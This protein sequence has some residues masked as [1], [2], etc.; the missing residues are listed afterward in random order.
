MRERYG[1]GEFQTEVKGNFLKAGNLGI[2]YVPIFIID[3]KASVVG[4]KNPD[5]FKKAISAVVNLIKEREQ[6]QA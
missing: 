5:A 1:K 6:K 3:E 4:V 2:N